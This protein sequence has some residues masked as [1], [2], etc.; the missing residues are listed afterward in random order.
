[1]STIC[2]MH[3][4]S[5]TPHLELPC[6][7]ARP[8]EGVRLGAAIAHRL[9]PA[10]ARGVRS[11]SGRRG[12]SA[13]TTLLA[14]LAAVLARLSGQGEVTLGAR[15]VGR[16]PARLV[17]RVGEDDSVQRLLDQTSTQ[18]RLASA[19]ARGL[20]LPRVQFG[21][22]Y[23]AVSGP[24]LSG[25]SDALAGCDV[26]LSV[27]DLGGSFECTWHYAPCLYDQATAERHFSH[28]RTLLLSMLRGEEQRVGD[29]ELL[30]TQ[31]RHRILVEWNATAS[32]YRPQRCVHELFEEQATRSPDAPAVLHAGGATSYAEL[33]HKANRLARCLRSQG[34][35]I[36]STV[37]I[38]LERS[39]DL[40]AAQLAVLKCGAVYV[41]IDNAFPAE[42]KQFI[43]RDTGACV[44][45]GNGNADHPDPEA[46][47]LLDIDTATLN[48]LDTGNLGTPLDSEAAAYI[49]YTSG[50]SG[51]A[52]GVVVP[53]RAINRLV[54][55]NGYA[56]FGPADR[57]AFAANPAFDAATMEVW[58]ALLNGG[59]CVVV[60]Q[61][62][63]LDARRFGTVLRESR[64][65]VLWMTV[66]LFNQ[67]AEEMADSIARLRYLII[68][69]DALN[70]E[71]VAGVLRRSPPGRLLNGY[72][73]TETTTF[74]LTHHIRAACG[75]EPIPLGRPIA[76]TQV[77][78]L[79][80]G[81]RPV[82]VGVVGE[83]YLAG[84]GLA[85]GYLNLPELSRERFVPDPYNPA[86][87]ERMYRTG[88]LGRW[89]A[90]GVVDYLGRNDA[91]VK[92]RGFRVELGE[93]EAR[94]REQPD[95]RDVAVAALADAGGDKRLVAYV[96][97]REDAGGGEALVAALRAG[98]Q[99]RLPAYMLPAAYVCLPALPL[100][101]NGKLDRR[102]LPS[103]PAQA[104][105]VQAGYEAP[106]GETETTLAELWCK[107]LSY[108][109]PGRYDNF[110]S[111]GGHSLSAARLLS[112]IRDVFGVELGLAAVFSAPHLAALAESIVDAQLA[113]FDLDELAGL[114]D[115]G[116]PAIAA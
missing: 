37:A 103:P 9:E 102:A 78:I 33:N 59:C 61:E 14:A 18:V 42:R 86:P 5:D 20:H 40:I 58:G 6:D 56:D 54:L 15:I 55:D 51:Q 70:P 83:I 91:Q 13:S 21:F 41:P 46:K 39:L 75:R 57:I 2:L 27:C 68:G 65:S 73:P 24:A 116:P 25:E 60:S 114:Y 108:E 67:F 45:I 12:I 107:L 80:A 72:G 50:S 30:T 19:A 79:D 71:A 85:H 63:L 101:P 8:Q 95:V 97:A 10:L 74:A 28:W 92:I 88:D 23:D 94:L 81:R 111:L 38:M 1:M 34:V 7:R 32:D 84:A 77:Y 87:G 26:A 17:L 22:V 48:R 29:L 3:G 89:R 47:G 113:Q 104:Y 93:I 112:R 35:R 115:G 52:K 11:L 66:G 99:E 105:A 69:G 90:D 106:E 109:R 4:E 110:F 16:A 31:E 43:L 44:V 96:V 49:M 100:T 64:V 53:H 62:L 76:N 82:P 98:L 36:G